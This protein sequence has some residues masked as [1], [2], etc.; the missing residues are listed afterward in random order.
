MGLPVQVVAVQQTIIQ[1][2]VQMEQLIL[3][4]AAVGQ[5]V[6]LLTLLL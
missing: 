4:A 3:V 1:Q 5:Q 6:E 2:Q